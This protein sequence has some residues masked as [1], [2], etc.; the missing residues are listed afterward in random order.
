MPP[1][2]TERLE[3]PIRVAIAGQ[4]R[5]G[6][7]IHARW[8]RRVPEQY[9]I[10]AV[11]D[12]LPDRRRE[13]REEL[14]CRTFSTH[15]EMLDTGGFDL[16]VNALPSQLH[17]RGSLDALL[18]GFHV[19]CEKPVAVKTW[20]FDRVVD[21]AGKAGRLYAP[22]QNS[23]FYPFFA[24]IREIID[25]G[26]IG[27]LVHA[28]INWSGFARRWDW[29][30]RQELLGGGLNNTGPHPLDHAI[31]LFGRRTPRVFC[32]MASGENCFGD[33]DDFA[34]VTLFGRREDP[35]VD[36][37]VS[38]YQAY[39]AED[40]Y[41]IGGTCGGIAGG[42]GGLRW[43][44]FDPAEAPRQT[45]MSG[46]SEGRKFCSEEL[47]WREDQWEPPASD[48]DP[49]AELS[50]GF[51]ENIHAVLTRGEQLVV[52]PEQVRRQVAVLEE[53][54]RQNRLPRRRREPRTR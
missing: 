7:D 50:R 23:R 36:V 48:L 20:D 29:Q 9:E 18:A 6:Y 2:K 40:R 27:R 12:E 49:F 38:S 31:L 39:P 52:R 22:F 15:T 1:K 46:W 21:T 4:G 8:L 53:C 26:Q 16:F 14:N 24:K 32:R 10:V 28:R 19:V 13:A 43:K 51:Y 3:S 5:S 37:L 25:S 35:V 17:V 54:H 42:P 11:C 41:V 30:T 34:S 33:A 47:P 45:L 44:W